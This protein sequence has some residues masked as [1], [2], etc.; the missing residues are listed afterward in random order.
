MS[1]SQLCARIRAASGPLRLAPHRHALRVLA[2]GDS[3]IYPADQELALDRPRGMSVIDS[4]HDGTG[5]TTSTVDWRRLAEHQAATVRPDA[6]VITLGGRDGGIS[7]PD[8]QHHLVSCCGP[9]W[10]ALYAGRL[11]PLVRAYA[12]G[13]RGRIYWLLLPA[14]QE[15][16]R[17]PLFE[18]VNE[19]LRLLAPEFAREL[20]LLPV[21][22]VISPG[23]FQTTI[24]YDGMQLQP[25]APDGI[26]MTHAGACVE[27]SLVVEALLA[28][29]LLAH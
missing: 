29:G 22:T 8:A 21:D 1:V 15:A 12:R 25:R 23:G 11:R 9:Q 10:L 17:A 20:H 2:T 28:D 7:L 16:L 5:V 18:A 26:H 6:T 24:T 13:G 19:A 3:M 27:R 4:R 14:P